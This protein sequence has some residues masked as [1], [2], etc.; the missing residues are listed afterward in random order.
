MHLY[1]RQ[2]FILFH[3]LLAVLIIYFLLRVIFLVFNYSFFSFNSIPQLA[4]VFLS[5]VRFDVSAI[6]ISNSVF[7]LFSI[8]PFSFFYQNWYQIILKIL[9]IVINGFFILMNCVD[10]AF[11]RFI[12][13]RTTCDLFDLFGLGDDIPN[14]MPVLLRDYWYLLLIWLGLMWLLLFLYNRIRMENNIPFKPYSVKNIPKNLLLMLGAGAVLVLAARGTFGLKPLRTIAASAFTSPENAPL[15]LNTTFTL[16]KTLGKEPLEEIRYFENGNEKKYFSIV[17]HYKSDSPF[18]PLNV[19]VIIMESFSKE[20]IGAL[21]DGAGYTPFL[22]S[23][24]SVSHACTNAYANSKKSIEGVPAVLSGLPALMSEPFIT[25]LYNGNKINSLASALKKKGYGTGFFHGGN[26]GTMGLDVFAKA[27]GFDFYKGKN[28]YGNRDYDGS[29]GIY[30]H[31]FFEYFISEMNRMKQPFMTAFF[32]VTSHHPFRLP[33]EFEGKFQEGTMPIH[34]SI[35]YADYS[36]RQFFEKAAMQPWFDNTLFVI[37]ADHT[38]PSEHPRYQTKKGIYEI[39]ILYY[40]HHSLI[41]VRDSGGTQ[42]CDIM[43][44]VLGLLHYEEPFVSFGSNIFDPSAP[45]FAINYLSDL[46]QHIAGERVIHFDGR[47]VTAVYDYRSDPLLRKNI[48]DPASDTLPEFWLMKSVIQQ[49][50]HSMLYNKLV[51]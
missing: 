36:L 46:Y 18:R 8:L 32:S 1:F 2:I 12:Q 28:E 14:T 47:K 23:L 30:D 43:P 37:T 42:Q 10:F 44:S 26:N 22:D 20:Y 29:W 11:F 51:P 4:I 16:I 5:G 21:N 45:R 34:K 35:R 7:I 33:E 40:Q 39:P 41:K 9:L 17:Q 27:A 31:K 50:N 48:F 3:R 15:V 19:V 13:K 25:S 24:I 49:F 38:G 6:V